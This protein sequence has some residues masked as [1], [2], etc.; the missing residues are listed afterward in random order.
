MTGAD[1][2]REL[3][4]R[5]ARDGRLPGAAPATAEAALGRIVEAVDAAVLAR[6]LVL[7]L[8]G[9]DLACAVGARRLLSFE[10]PGPGDLPAGGAALSG[11]PLSAEDAGAVAALLHALAGRGGAFALD[12][13]APPSGSEP[14]FGG[15]GA[16]QLAAA[17]GLASAPAPADPLEAGLAALGAGVIGALL[18]E[19]EE[20]AL[21]VGDTED[22]ALAEAAGAVLDRLLLPEFPLLPTLEAAGALTFVAPGGARHLLLAGHLGRYL[23]AAVAGDDAAG[24]LTRWRAAALP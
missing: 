22:A 3:L 10:A 16:A 4:R 19:G 6:R 7:R 21:L 14:A 12:L 20:I 18:I 8:G 11:R 24:T 1:R 15:I 13:A 2:I 17:L 23:L 9:A 5:A